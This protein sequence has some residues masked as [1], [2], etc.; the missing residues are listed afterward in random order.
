NLRLD[1]AGPDHPVAALVRRR[2]SARGMTAL[3]VALLRALAVPARPVAG[4]RWDGEAFHY[5]G[6]AE[7][8]LP[9][10]WLPVDPALDQFPADGSRLRL[11][12][13]VGADPLVLVPLVG[14]LRPRLLHVELAR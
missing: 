14:R 3:Y 10:G 6:W 11:A 2:A 7:V 1:S 13:G 12:T 4:L 9:D 8:R 5:H